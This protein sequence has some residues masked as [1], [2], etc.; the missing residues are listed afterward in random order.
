MHKELE[1]DINISELDISKIR[2]IEKRIYGIYPKIV[3]IQND[4]SEY[5]IETYY[6]PNYKAG[7]EI[8]MEMDLFIEKIPGYKKEL[9]I[10]IKLVLEKKSKGVEDD[11]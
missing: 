5:V 1:T 10:E 8:D 6:S 9:D 3:V 2:S 7:Q 11:L 4:N